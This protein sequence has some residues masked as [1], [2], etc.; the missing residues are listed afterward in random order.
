MQWRN[1]LRDD[2][3]LSTAAKAAGFVLT[4]YANGT[5]AARPARHTIAAGMTAS[6]RTVDK[7]LDELE[8]AAFLTIDP[9]K[10]ERPDGT[11]ARPGGK[12]AN[13]FTLTLPSAQDLHTGSAQ[14]MQPECA[15]SAHES[16]SYGTK[17]TGSA[18]K[19]APACPNPDCAD[20]SPPYHVDGCEYAP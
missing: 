2:T 16:G 1:A 7:A 5:G 13:R 20:L 17:A 10:L 8:Q 3:T 18:R 12:T 9:P 11:F 4:T 15:E 19:G 6:V 14:S